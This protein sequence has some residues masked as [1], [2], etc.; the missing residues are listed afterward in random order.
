MSN[1]KIKRY[2]NIYNKKRRFDKKTFY[3]IGISFISLVVIVAVVYFT[4]LAIN[5]GVKKDKEENVLSESSIN[6]QET[7]DD[8]PKE[9]KKQEQKII[10]KVMPLS[11]LT[12]KQ[13]IN[14]FIKSS[15]D[16][17]VNSIIIPVKSYDGTLNY[18]SSV[19]EATK[20]NTISKTPLDLANIVTSIK[21]EGLTPIAQIYAFTDNKA[22]AV[23]R[24][25]TY[26]Y[27]NNKNKA[28]LFANPLKKGENIKFL[29]PYKDSSRKYICDIVKEVSNLG[30]SK[31]L[32]DGVNFPVSSFDTTTLTYS[33][34]VSKAD[35]MKQFI[36]ELDETEVD[37][38]LSFDWSSIDAQDEN[39]VYGGDIST[40]GA[41][42]ISP[43]LN[44]TTKPSGSKG[45]VQEMLNSSISK[46]KQDNEDL[47]IIPRIPL[48][49]D[50]QS[51]IN[52]LISISVD[53]Y[54]T[55]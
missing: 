29:N 48:N 9:E 51:Y 42:S 15:K 33:N 40:F 34:G 43:I 4:L 49:K 18:S 21:N 55:Q 46:L 39:N 11:S 17:A 50:I 12:S 26:C 38:I 6:S 28:K 22:A 24:D 37:Y 41:K 14:E 30:F 31:V 20:W 32:M 47:N 36:K 19:E 3:Q 16:N 2:S 25:N 45:T 44:T 7:T 8:K 52:A 23:D 27:T 53:S 5:S 13:K 10:G 1:K 54:I 35:I